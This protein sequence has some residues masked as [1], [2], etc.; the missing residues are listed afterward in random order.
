VSRRSEVIGR[1]TRLGRA[2][3]SLWMG[4]E[5]LNVASVRA[6]F[7]ES[8]LDRGRFRW[9]LRSREQP[10]RLVS[11]RLRVAGRFARVRRMSTG[12]RL[13]LQ[14]DADRPPVQVEVRVVC[15]RLER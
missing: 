14:A 4:F 3:I 9:E 8:L 13:I 6:Q 7:G 12:D 2:A 15:S 5:L 11:S 10:P 1:W